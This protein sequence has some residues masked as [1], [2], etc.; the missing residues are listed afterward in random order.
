MPRTEALFR[1]IY[2][3][4]APSC[5]LDFDATPELGIDPDALAARI[6]KERAA[7][8]TLP[9]LTARLHTLADFHA[10]LFTEHG[11]YAAGRRAPA[12]QADL[13]TY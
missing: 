10:W 8:A 6:A 3:L 9:A 12:V 2:S 5:D 1:W 13:G 7:L 11:A 4:D